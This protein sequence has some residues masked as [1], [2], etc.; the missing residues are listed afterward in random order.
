M[1]KEFLES[2]EPEAFITGPAGSGKTTDLKQ[3][4][5]TLNE[6]GINYL[7]TA[8]THKAKEVL[9]SKLPE[10]TPIRTLHSWLKKRPGINSKAKHIKHIMTNHQQGKPEHL[11]LLIVDEFSFINEED[12]MS[13][14]ELQDELNLTTYHCM[15]CGTEAS[16][17][18]ELEYDGDVCGFCEKC[19]ANMLFEEVVIPPIKVLYVGDLNQLSPVKGWS[20]VS[21]HKPFWKELTVVHRNSTQLL[22]PLTKL[23]RMIEGKEPISYLKPNEDFVRNLNI[24]EHYKLLVSDKIMLAYTNKAVEEHNRKIQGRSIPIEGDIIYI[25]TLRCDK[26]LVKIHFK[27]NKLM[28]LT[29]PR[30]L[31]TSESKYNPFKTLGELNYVKYYEFDDGTIVPG[32]F[33]SYQNKLIRDELGKSLVAKNKNNL[34]SIKEYKL[35]KCINDYVSIMDFNHCMTIHKSQGSEFDY[36]FIDSADLAI[37][38]DIQEQMKLLYVAISRAR[39]SVYMNN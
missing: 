14:G 6:L 3:T 4:V 31:L 34:D 15:K 9:E 39:C 5:I 21:P 8:Y 27:T 7:V 23:V 36:V 30:G 38:K 37:C 10:G 28:Q 29:V 13:I 26:Q 2:D 17:D 33:G 25:P 16:E 19:N 35:Y 1:I 24:D 32:I 18:T 12:Y 20:A 22:K 11:Q